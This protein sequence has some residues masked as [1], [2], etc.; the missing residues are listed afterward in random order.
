MGLPLLNVSLGTPLLGGEMFFGGLGM[1]GVSAID[2]IPFREA[3]DLHQHPRQR[4][5]PS[6]KHRLIMLMSLLAHLG[7]EGEIGA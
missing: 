4:H 5:Q 6:Y 1:S 2:I 3:G 7:T